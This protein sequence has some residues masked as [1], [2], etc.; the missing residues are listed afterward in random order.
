MSILLL[1]LDTKYNE[2]SLWEKVT[3][4]TQTYSM[5][6]KIVL[7]DGRTIDF[8]ENTVARFLKLPKEGLL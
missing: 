1:L 8:S 7:V 5:E 2:S 6:I 4:F 3:H